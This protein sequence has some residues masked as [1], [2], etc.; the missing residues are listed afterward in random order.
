MTP[1]YNKF[2]L[3]SEKLHWNNSKRGFTVKIT[4]HNDFSQVRENWD[5]VHY[6]KKIN[7][8]EQQYL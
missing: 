2:I 6:I 5:N 3:E 1:L 7:R 8:D 4:R